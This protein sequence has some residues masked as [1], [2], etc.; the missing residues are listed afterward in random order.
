MLINQHRLYHSNCNSKSS[1]NTSTNTNTND[2]EDDVDLIMS[3]THESDIVNDDHS[4]I[5]PI[6]LKTLWDNITTNLNLSNFI[7]KCE[8]PNLSPSTVIDS[9]PNTLINMMLWMMMNTNQWSKK[10]LSM[11]E[12]N[13]NGYPNQLFE[14]LFKNLKSVSHLNWIANLS[15]NYN[16]NIVEEQI[17]HKWISEAQTSN[18]SSINASNSKIINTSN[19]QIN[20]LKYFS[21]NHQPKMANHNDTNLNDIIINTDKFNFIKGK[22]KINLDN[23]QAMI[24]SQNEPSSTMISAKTN[25]PNA[26]LLESNLWKHFHSMTTEM[27]ITKSGR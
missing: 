8:D 25:E 9:N 20:D 16:N 18:L 4:S 1:N 19:G 13:E 17:C 14:Y 5:L 2:D 3:T 24:G 27:V 6:K 12:M 22:H 26:E 21:F 10:D 7:N 15:N 23:E 11:N